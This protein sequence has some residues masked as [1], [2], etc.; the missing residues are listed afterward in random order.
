MQ[1]LLFAVLGLFVFVAV[2]GTIDML[3]QINNL[4]DE[5]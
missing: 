5:E 3:K 4:K 1:Y 2:C